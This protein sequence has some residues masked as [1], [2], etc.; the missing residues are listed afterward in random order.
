MFQKFNEFLNLKPDN[1]FKPF[2]NRAL[3]DDKRKSQRQKQT[4]KI[5]QDTG[6][7]C[8]WIVRMLGYTLNILL[9]GLV[10]ICCV[11]FGLFQLFLTIRL[12]FVFFFKT[13]SNASSH[14][15]VIL[16]NVFP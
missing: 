6:S 10:I 15:V 1:R 12:I 7:N 9:P 13:L 4:E 14:F 16:E 5:N 2:T 3:S 8:F 11:T